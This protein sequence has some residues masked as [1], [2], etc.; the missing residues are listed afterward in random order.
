MRRLRRVSPLLITFLVSL[1]YCSQ[2]C[3]AAGH[4]HAAASTTRLDPHSADATPCHSPS[5][6]P[7]HTSDQ[8][9][10][11]GDHFFLRSTSFGADT[12][13]ASGTVLSTV[14]SFFRMTSFLEVASVA[15]GNPPDPH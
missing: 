10:D 13:T 14:C 5:P 12:L 2:V 6:A 3:V 1:F 4:V 11:C 7:Q 15:C 8:C 9:P